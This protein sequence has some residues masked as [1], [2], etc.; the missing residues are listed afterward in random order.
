MTANPTRAQTEPARD[1]MVDQAM[2][3]WDG[4]TD[5]ERR[6]VF[7]KVAR[8]VSAFGLTKNIDHLV[9]LAEG[10]DG[11]V[12]IEKVPGFSE[13]RRRPPRP[14]AEQGEGVGMAEVV[15]RLRE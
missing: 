11:M 14:L 2:A 10:V 9:K 12:T 4:L 7:R 13:A 15:R 8:A 5:G 1:E 6:E 3:V